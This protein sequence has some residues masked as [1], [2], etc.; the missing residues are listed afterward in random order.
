M[1]ELKVTY[2][3]ECDLCH[4]VV[5]MD[6]YGLDTIVMPYATENQLRV[7]LLRFHVC[8]YCR[9]RLGCIVS[10]YLD[11]DVHTNKALEWKDLAARWKGGM[12]E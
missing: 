10:H 9:K 4:K 6:K 2:T 12:I 8:P 5:E 3:Q 1:S 11:Y 7:P